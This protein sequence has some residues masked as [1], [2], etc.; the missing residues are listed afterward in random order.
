MSIPFYFT[1]LM[2]ISCTVVYIEGKELQVNFCPV[3]N[4]VITENK[5]P[6]QSIQYSPLST[7]PTASSK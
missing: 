1:S 6:I 7:F 5:P 2:S 4:R 3:L